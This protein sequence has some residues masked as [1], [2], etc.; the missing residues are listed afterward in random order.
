MS[1]RVT[2]K[3]AF[4]LPSVELVRTRFD[5]F[6]HGGSVPVFDEYSVPSGEAMMHAPFGHIV[7]Q[8][9]WRDFKQS[10][11]DIEGFIGA[12]KDRIVVQD[13]RDSSKVLSVF[14]KPKDWY[15]LLEVRMVNELLIALFPHNFP[16]IRSH[17]GHND[18]LGQRPTPKTFFYS[19]FKTDR[20]EGIQ[21][22]TDSLEI[23]F[24][25]LVWNENKFVLGYPNGQT[26]KSV[27]H[28]FQLVL[29]VTNQIGLP[30]K[31]LGLDPHADNFILG[32]DGGEYY[33]DI[34]F[35]PFHSYDEEFK[36]KW[37]SGTSIKK[38]QELAR[39]K[40]R[41]FTPRQLRQA[42]EGLSLLG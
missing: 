11:G 41:L 29:D 7:R 23:G 31:K 18:N 26:S 2:K 33:I 38:L 10:L 42:E 27:H 21:A 35:G 1:E 32:Q 24:T 6:L 22:V 16:R 30:L 36:L 5:Q 15:F 28:P 12:G 39:A 3:S 9:D 40:P 37:E 8:S 25:G 13:P 20:I 17:F 4:P 14:H 19:G 34:L